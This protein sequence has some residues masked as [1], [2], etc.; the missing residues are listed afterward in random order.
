MVELKHAYLIACG[1]PQDDPRRQLAVAFKNLTRRSSVLRCD[2]AGALAEPGARAPGRP[3]PDTGFAP[4]A[5]A[6]SCRACHLRAWK[7]ILKGRSRGSDWYLVVDMATLSYQDT[8]KLRDWIDS[9]PDGEIARNRFT[10][11]LFRGY[12][13]TYLVSGA[14]VVGLA[15]LNKG[16]HPDEYKRHLRACIAMQVP[17]SLTTI[18]L[19]ALG[20]E[21]ALC[22]LTK[23]IASIGKWDD[24]E[25]T[26]L[27]IAV[28]LVFVLNRLI[29]R[30]SVVDVFCAVEFLSLVL[31]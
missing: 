5:L 21:G 23:P 29:T 17:V 2:H 19:D 10:M 8:L 4:H 7:H 1:L 16:R 13:A 22:S 30:N 3:A 28:V 26:P 18:V 31:K 24:I 20:L 15:M 25:L 12:S 6:A 27:H 9:L 14:G 11:C